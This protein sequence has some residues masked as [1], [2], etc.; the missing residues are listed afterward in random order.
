MR[1]IVRMVAM[2]GGKK[3]WEAYQR[4]Q[5]EKKRADGPRDTPPTRR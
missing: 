5:A 3:A 2:W 4:R 1:W